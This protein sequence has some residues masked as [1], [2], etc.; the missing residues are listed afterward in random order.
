VRGVEI[1]I[2]LYELAEHMLRQRLHREQPH[3]PASQIESE[4]NRWRV[5][6]PGAEHGDAPGRVVRWPRS[7]R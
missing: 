3:R 7:R 6:R 5:A 1:A 4:V 2:E